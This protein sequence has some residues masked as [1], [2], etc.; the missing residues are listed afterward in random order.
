M[1]YR[2]EIKDKPTQFD[3]V[4]EGIKKDILDLGIN[5]IK[6][7]RFIQV[8]NIEGRLFETEL[9]RICEDLL[10]DKIS[11]DYFINRDS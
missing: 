3:A 8:Y 4:G 2:I 7:V 1:V 6:E 9:K 5:S 10:T 11:Q